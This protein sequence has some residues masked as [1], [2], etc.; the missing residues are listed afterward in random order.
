MADGQGQISHIDLV[1]AER[2]EVMR[3]PFSSLYGN[4][5]GG[6][7]N[8]F[9][10]NGGPGH[11]ATPYF[12]AG[13]YG[14]RKYGLMV[15][16]EQ[17]NFNYVLDA[18]LLH[19]N[20][21]RDHSNAD[22]QNDNLKLGLKLGADTTL[23]IVAN[24]VS[25][26]AF[27]PLGLTAAQLQANAAGAGTNAIAFNTRKSVDQSQGGLVLTH[28]FGGNDTLTVTPYYGERHTIQ[29]LATGANGVI[30]L[31]RA[32]FGLNGN[33]LHTGTIA[34]TPFKVVTGI[35]GNE[36]DD[37]RLTYTNKIGRAHV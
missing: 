37:H 35:E 24:N 16:G 34:G 1:S 21:Y 9:T 30:D 32:Y 20:G 12:S 28:R 5:A 17:G 33:W 25:L 15:D 29:Y 10:Q 2:I 36:N 26:R 31:K 22:R 7:I 13:S 11:N 4:S 19:T 23:G 27:D 3:G 14:Q 18:G 6:V 8:V